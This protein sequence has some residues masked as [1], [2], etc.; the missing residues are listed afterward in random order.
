M[1]GDFMNNILKRIFI[2]LTLSTCWFIVIS[3]IKLFFND[4]NWLSPSIIYTVS[5]MLGYVVGIINKDFVKDY[6]K[7]SLNVIIIAITAFFLS[8]FTIGIL[9]DVTNWIEILAAPFC[10]FSISLLFTGIDDFHNQF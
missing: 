3:V 4:K 9:Y 8:S 2:V 6:F 1:K 5:I 7:R 10:F